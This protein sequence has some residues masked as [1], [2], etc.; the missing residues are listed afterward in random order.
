[1]YLN[2]KARSQHE[3][4]VCWQGMW[5]WA[6]AMELPTRASQVMWEDTWNGWSNFTLHTAILMQPPANEVTVLFSPG[7]PHS[8]KQPCYEASDEEQQTVSFVCQ[9]QWAGSGCLLPRAEDSE[10]ICHAARRKNKYCNGLLM[11]TSLRVRSGSTC[12]H[13]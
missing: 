1:M 3:S 11:A 6:D 9:I 12:T 8:Q 2:W 5:G 4:S 10:A 13:Y 7:T